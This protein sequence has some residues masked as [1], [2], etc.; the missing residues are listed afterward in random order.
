[1]NSILT[2]LFHSLKIVALVGGE[3]KEGG[4]MQYVCLLLGFQ[5]HQIYF[6]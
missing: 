5:G 3:V 6:R 4:Q 1:M 2:L